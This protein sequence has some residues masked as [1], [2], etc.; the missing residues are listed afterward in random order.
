MIVA[1]ASELCAVHSVQPRH[2]LFRTLLLLLF[3]ASSKGRF[4]AKGNEL[5]FS[6]EDVNSNGSVHS[7]RTK[8][9]CT[10]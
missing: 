3:S 9:N 7:G 6:S 1:A 8:P 10:V 5:N 2:A 4:T